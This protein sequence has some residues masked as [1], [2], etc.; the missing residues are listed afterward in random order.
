MDFISVVAI[1]IVVLMAVVFTAVFVS[2][3]AKYKSLEFESKK[4]QEDLAEKE[5]LL[6]KEAMIK[7]KDA[8]QTEREQLNEEERERRQE[9]SRQEAKLAQREDALEDKIQDATEREAAA[10]RKMDELLEKE[11]Y[12]AELVQKQTSELERIS[13]MSAE[14]AKNMLLEQLKNDLAQEQMQLIR[15]NEA[16]IKEKALEQSQEILS[17]TMQRCVMDQVVESTVSVVSLPN[18]E[19]KGRIIGREGRNIRTLETLTGVDL[20]IDDTP[21]AVVLS[22]FDPVRR[23]V[24]KLALEKLISDGRIH[25]V[26]IE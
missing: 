10:Q 4:K 26:R 25:P 11:D 16:K 13:G 5:Q 2:Q 19:M 12:L 23:E 3:R 9:L 17:T 21:E 6:V 20:I 1:V 18:D 24:A 7:A 15:E 8:L 14:D 22:S